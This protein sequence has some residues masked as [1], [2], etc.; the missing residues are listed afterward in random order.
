M[1]KVD[2]VKDYFEGK[3]FIQV[4]EIAFLGMRAPDGT[5]PQ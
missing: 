5:L 4:I 3:I 1:V 2:G